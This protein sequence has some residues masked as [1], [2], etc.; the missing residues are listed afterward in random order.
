MI[1]AIRP[2]TTVNSCKQQNIFKMESTKVVSLRLAMG[3]YETI[4]LECEAKGITITE[5]FDRK[6]ATAKKVKIIKSQIVEKMEQ[7]YD[8]GLEYPSL[9]QRKLRS[10]IR[11]V[12]GEL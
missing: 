6:I 10:V 5:W 12:E 11:F 9:A 4:I 8:F 7:V 2:K 1:G 3:T